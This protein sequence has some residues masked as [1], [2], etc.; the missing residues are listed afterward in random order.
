MQKIERFHFYYADAAAY[1]KLDLGEFRYLVEEGFIRYGI[2]GRANFHNFV[3]VAA[4]ENYFDK[5]TLIT[6]RDVYD[7]DFVYFSHNKLR[8][9]EGHNYEWINDK[10]LI[11]ISEFESFGGDLLRVYE[12]GGDGSLT[13]DNAY[14][15]YDFTYRIDQDGLLEGVRFTKEDLDRYLNREIYVG[16]EYKFEKRSLESYIKE[17]NNISFESDQDWFLF[18]KPQ[19]ARKPSM[20]LWRALNLYYDFYGAQIEQPNAEALLD[21]MQEYSSTAIRH[22][23]WRVEVHI[24]KKKKKY[25]FESESLG[26]RQQHD[27]ESIEQS[28]DWLEQYRKEK[29]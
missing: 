2:D 8:S 15:S 10:K 1:L 7:D 12:I 9:F 29:N 19:R 22:K 4:A 20:Y 11:H 16:P 17:K 18:Y 21:F 28:L 25:S 23:H 6:A 24:E 26:H 5:G 3:K 14:D 27:I 13:N